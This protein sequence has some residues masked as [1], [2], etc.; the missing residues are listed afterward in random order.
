MRHYQYRT[1]PRCDICQ[2]TAHRPSYTAISST[3][4]IPMSINTL[5]QLRIWLLSNGKPSSTSKTDV[6][7]IVRALDSG[8]QI[9]VRR[10]YSKPRSESRT[11]EGSNRELRSASCSGLPQTDCRSCGCMHQKSRIFWSDRKC[12]MSPGWVRIRTRAVTSHAH[13]QQEG[14]PVAGLMA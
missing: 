5:R 1:Q 9:R 11:K 13:C 10:T 14:V 4:P 3:S 7:A 8:G 12:S 6:L 2:R